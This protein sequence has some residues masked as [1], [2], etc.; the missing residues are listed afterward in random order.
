[1]MYW[2]MVRLEVSVKRYH[3]PDSEICM[4]YYRIKVYISNVSV[5]LENE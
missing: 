5:I 1:M 2:L 3:G 4:L